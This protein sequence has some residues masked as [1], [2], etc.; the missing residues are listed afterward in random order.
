MNSKTIKRG[1]IFYANLNP[2]TGS[3]QGGIRPVLVIQNNIQNRNSPTVIVAAIT[4][5][6]KP[7]LNTHVSLKD[8]SFL[9]T[10]SIV[11]LEQLRTIDKS[12]LKEH[13]GSL[14][15]SLMRRVNVALMKSTALTKHKQKTGII[16]NDPGIELTLCNA[17]ASAFYYSPEHFIKRVDPAQYIKEHCCICN[18][19][20][21]YDFIIFKKSIL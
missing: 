19:R 7:A 15:D 20:T 18:T 12:R 13:L 3:E 21:G 14:E 17:C 1:D 8:C 6:K 16:K 10:T 4:S 9:T 11:M 5:K 2:V